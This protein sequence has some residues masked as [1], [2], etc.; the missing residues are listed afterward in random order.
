[1]NLRA[2]PVIL[3]LVL[4]GSGPAGCGGPSADEAAAAPDSARQR[5]LA[6][7]ERPVRFVE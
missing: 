4:C 7:W 1:M 5:V 2:R 3:L 6:F